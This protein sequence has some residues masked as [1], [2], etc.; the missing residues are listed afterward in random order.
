MVG[1]GWFARILILSGY[2][3]KWLADVSG[4]WS[5]DSSGGG[6]AECTCPYGINGTQSAES[7]RLAG[8]RAPCMHSPRCS[9]TRP[10]HLGRLHL[11]ASPPLLP[12]TLIFPALPSHPPAHSPP[13]YLL[14]SHLSRCGNA[15]TDETREIEKREKKTPMIES[16]GRS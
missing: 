12:T 3:V 11:Q 7:W 5:I 8:A 15:I 16:N 14:Y 4:I 13:S 9:C 10:K 6:F 2:F 1:E